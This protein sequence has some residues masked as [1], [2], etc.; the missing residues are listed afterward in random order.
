ML[1]PYSLEL[2]LKNVQDSPYAICTDASNKGHRK[3]FPVSIRCFDQEK[4]IVNA[5]IDV[6]EDPKETSIAIANQLIVCIHNVGLNP[7]KLV[8]YGGTMHL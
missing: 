1:A 7:N 5:I 6:Y 4:G 8:S 2:I 3:M